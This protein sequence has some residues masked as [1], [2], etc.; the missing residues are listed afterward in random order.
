MFIMLGQTATPDKRIKKKSF[1]FGKTEKR[2]LECR[3]WKR[4]Q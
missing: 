2:G 3:F 4:L 1:D